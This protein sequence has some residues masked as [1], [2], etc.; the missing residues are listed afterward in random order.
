MSEITVIL[1][2]KEMIVSLDSDTLRVDRPGCKLERVPLNMIARVIVKGNPMVSCEIFRVLAERN[3]PVTL[4]PLRGKGKP[5]YVGSVLS[6]SV[7]KRVSQ[8]KAIHNEQSIL[9]VS[10]WLLSVKLRGQESVLT[11]LSK[12]SEISEPIRRCRAE[13][14]KADNRN[15]LMGH[16]GVAAAYY[17]KTI[18]KLIP[19]KW[20]FTGR[21][22]QPPKDPV[23]ALF[24]LSYTIAGSE[25]SHAVQ[26]AGLDPAAGFLHTP[27]NG[28]D[29][30]MLD[31][32]EPLRPE[33]DWFVLC[34]LDNPLHVKDFAVSKDGCFLDKKGR[35]AYYEAWATWQDAENKNLRK[36]AGQIINEMVRYF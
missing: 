26:E 7:E 28:R 22:R 29:S 31:I 18:G 23:N 24:S 20:S 5:A 30:L 34:L 3:I 25:V 33:T 9:A 4:L 6:S 16:E 15:S 12:D 27:L 1:D 21:N 36:T 11:Q 14:Q 2:K 17:F 35:K 32:L 10:R 13:L 8:Y 19:A